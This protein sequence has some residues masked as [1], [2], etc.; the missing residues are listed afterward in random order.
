MQ[1]WR[2]FRCQALGGPT[3]WW[4]PYPLRTHL[5]CQKETVDQFLEGTKG[6]KDNSAP[7]WLL[8]PS[9]YSAL[10]SLV[11]PFIED[12]L[13]VGQIPV[14]GFSSISCAF[15]VSSS[16]L[17]FSCLFILIPARLQ[18][19]SLYPSS[20]AA[21][22]L[23]E[24]NANLISLSWCSLNLHI[25]THKLISAGCEGRKREIVISIFNAGKVLRD[26]AA[27]GAI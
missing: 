1:T 23:P 15:F 3:T 8:R 25:L 9:S 21:G 20:A 17:S 14:P 5:H 7:R 27:M 4:I 10:P 16:A 26:T 19:A 24:C 18:V 2:H 6:E 13:L 11:H 22:P 12:N